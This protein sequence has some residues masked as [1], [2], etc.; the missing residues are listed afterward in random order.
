MPAI[1]L[2]SGLAGAGRTYRIGPA[3]WGFV[4]TNPFELQVIAV[5]VAVNRVQAVECDPCQVFRGWDTIEDD[6][7]VVG[8]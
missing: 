8:Q 3:I 6:C 7:F 1:A 5:G 2:G 4:E